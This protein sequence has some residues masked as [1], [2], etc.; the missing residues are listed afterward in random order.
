LSDI[1]KHAL[2]ISGDSLPMHLA[3]GLG[4]PTL[5]LFTCT[6][7]WEIHG[8]GIQKKLVSPLLAEFFYQRKFDERGITSISV[9]TV[10]HSALELLADR[11]VGADL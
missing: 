11:Y 8:Y 10:Y 9:D 6:S 5:S 3:L 4:V 1:E 7:P 2:L